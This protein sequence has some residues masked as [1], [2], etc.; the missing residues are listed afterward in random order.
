MTCSRICA[1]IMARPRPYTS[2]VNVTSGGHGA[3]VL[4]ACRRDRFQAFVRPRDRRGQCEEIP[5]ALDLLWRLEGQRIHFHH[6]LMVPVAIVAFARLQA[7]ERG[8]LSVV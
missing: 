5:L 8:A 6:Q 4:L 3:V 1:A 2:A 7:V